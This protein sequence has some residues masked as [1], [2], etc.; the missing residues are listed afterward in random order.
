[1]E[2][3]V[4]DLGESST[5]ISKRSTEKVQAKTQ[6]VRETRIPP[7]LVGEPCDEATAW[8]NDVQCQCL[9]DTGSQVTCISQSLYQQ[10][11]SHRKLH[12]IS[13]VLEIEGAAGQL[14]PYLGYITVDV[15]FLKEQCGTNAIHHNVSLGL[16]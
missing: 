16:S 4:A 10:C 6:E 14:V 3:T 1:M 2:R 9:L 7:G 11:L 5:S 15:K 12:S 13:D 8:L